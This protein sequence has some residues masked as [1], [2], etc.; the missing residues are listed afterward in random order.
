MEEDTV[1][2]ENV[3]EPKILDFTKSTEEPSILVKI[4]YTLYQPLLQLHAQENVNSLEE[5]VRGTWSEEEDIKLLNLV[6]EN[7]PKRWSYLATILGGRSGKQCRERYLNHLDPSINKDEWSAE[8]DKFIIQFALENGNQ[9]SAMS[10][11]LKGRTANAI[12]NR[13]NSTL[14]KKISDGMETSSIEQNSDSN[15]KKRKISKE[16]EI[17]NEKEI[18]ILE[19]SVDEFIKSIDFSTFSKYDSFSPSNIITNWSPNLFNISPE[20]TNFSEIIKRG[21]M[22]E[23]SSEKENLNP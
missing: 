8:E 6:G 4:P 16:I 12:K 22:E 7:G 19:S 23:N 15:P 18:D 5:P 10:K 13:W 21:K 14:K 3:N 17:P 9:W 11:H 1:M 2:E 20:K